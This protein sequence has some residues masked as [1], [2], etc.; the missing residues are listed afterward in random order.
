MKYLWNATTCLLVAC[1]LWACHPQK[2]EPSPTRL[3][4][5]AGEL[6][7]YDSLAES[8]V[9]VV[10][11]SHFKKNVLAAESQEQLQALIQRLATFQP[12]KIVLEWEPE[13]L[14]RT[15]REYQAYWA[16]TFAIAERENE[17]YQLGF[18]LGLYMGH[19][20]LYLFDDQTEFIGSLENFSFG[21]FTEYAIQ[22]DGDFYDKHEETLL[23]T[24]RYN[25][26]ILEGYAL[27]D[28]IALLNSPT[29]QQV[30]AHRMHM[31]EIRVGIQKNWIGPDWLG[32]WYRRNVRMVGNI[33]KLAEA[34]DR[35]LI[36]VG[37][38][39]KWTLD[40]LFRNIPD[41][42]VVSSWELLKAGP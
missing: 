15:N 26:G 22:N 20:S 9:M 38:N 28:R 42:E 18:R 33:L 4:L 24:F 21:A 12:T 14:A 13:L 32:R 31:Y 41:F 34:G 23:E 29:A 11:T 8:K 36:I 27:Y 3:E 6:K 30:N 35:I 2:V 16:G 19:D 17:V 7:G 10:G 25:Q 37:D 1:V 40:M 39:H 5:A